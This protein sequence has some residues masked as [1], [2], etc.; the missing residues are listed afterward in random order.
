MSR[1][2]LP[3]VS[4]WLIH[5]HGAPRRPA[6]RAVTPDPSLLAAPLN[7]HLSLL[8]QGPP[9]LLPT[10]QL[11]GVGFFSSVVMKVTEMTERWQQP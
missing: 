10:P 3:R 7:P 9:S 1:L 8:S 6:P 11:S 4:E 2:S 5:G